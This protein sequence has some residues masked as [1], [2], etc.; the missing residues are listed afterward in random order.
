MKKKIVIS[1]PI[2]SRSGYG[3]MA[4]FAYRSLKTAEEACEVYL[5]PTNWGATGNIFELSEEKKEID[6]LI[7]KTQQLIQQTGG[8][9]NFDISIQVTIPNEWK[10]LAPINIG[11]TAGIETNGISPAW[12]QPSMQM[13]KIIV[14]SEHAK[15]SF[16]NTVF[17]DQQG[18]KYSVTKPIEVCHFPVRDFKETELNLDFKHDFNFLTVCQWSPRKNVE[19]TIQAFIEEFGQEN[20]GLVLKINTANDSLLD[21]EATETKLK[22]LL[23]KFPNR[24]CS[25]Y[26]LHGHMS[27]SEMQSLY[28]HPKIKAIVSSTH[29]EGFGFPLFEASYNELPVIATDWSGHLDFLTVKDEEGIEKKLFA[30][31]DYE[32]KPIAQEHTWQGVLEAG[33]LWAYPLQSHL[34]S[35]M[36]EL[37]KDH[38]RFKSWSKKLSSHIRKQYTEE[39]LYDKFYELVIGEKLIK[40][41]TKEL[42]KISIIGSVYDADEFIEG[43]LEDITSQTIF[44]EK[45]ELILINANSPGN[46]E[47]VIKKY[48]EKYPNI[49]YKKLD[50][51]PGIYAVWNMAVKMASGEFLT[52][53]NMDDRKAPAS[54]EK[55][56]KALF[57]AKDSDLVYA[58]SFIVHEPNKKWSEVPRDSQ[59]YNFEQF[60]AKAMLRGN[61]PHNNPMWRKSLHDKFG[62][63]NEQHKSAS[64]W[65]FWLTCVAGGTKFTKINE[66]L[67]V[68]Y[69]NPKGI[70]TNFENFSWKQKEEEEIFEKFSNIIK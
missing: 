44:K 48:M 60:S 29:G 18:N 12:L 35:K 13:D 66:V 30:K 17:A 19:Q 16:I 38:G 33:T 4:R 56:A 42:P 9:P 22:Q 40:I 43:Y 26:L 54:I 68:Y 14:I 32:L 67:G 49:I 70:S 24:K 58:D 36:R 20:V 31:V 28:K 53:A 61:L 62:Y 37:H 46:E 39:K 7:V 41:D 50:Q 21:Q 64:D 34:K 23:Q 15:S 8:Q 55:H 47:P 59:R 3:E 65:E 51:D 45:C 11:Y 63:F 2:L 69:F 52:N 10:K 57:V 6:S 27:E 1:G 25:V 5:L